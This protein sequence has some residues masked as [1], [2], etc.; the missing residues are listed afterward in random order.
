M[1]YTRMKEKAEEDTK[2]YKLFELVN[3]NEITALQWSYNA[4]D[5]RTFMFAW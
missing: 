3:G 4:L 1:A 5:V 2:T